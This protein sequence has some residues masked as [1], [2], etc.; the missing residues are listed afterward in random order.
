M[1]CNIYIRNKGDESAADCMEFWEWT[2]ELLKIKST[3]IHSIKQ[4]AFSVI[5]E[6]MQSH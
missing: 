4:K 5:A 6:H 1:K 2:V 3:I